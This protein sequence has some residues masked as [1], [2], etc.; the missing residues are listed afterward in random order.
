[1][2]SKVSVKA[3]RGLFVAV[4]LVL[5][6]GLYVLPQFVEYSVAFQDQNQVAVERSLS[7]F[8]YQAVGH[9]RRGAWDRFA[10]YAAEVPFGA[11]FARVGAAAGAFSK[12]HH[13][14]V[15]FGYK[16]F[17]SDNFWITALVEIGL[18]G[19]V[20]ITLLLVAIL[21]FGVRNFFKI[22]RP[23]LKI[24]HLAVLCSLI[25]IFMGLYGAEGVL[26]NPES[27]FFWFFSGVLMKLPLLDDK[28]A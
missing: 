24:L 17:F 3:T 10:K 8:D 27:S 4:G 13:Q 18:P 20:F 19:M 14:D 9:A 12:L 22:R 28:Q 1:M 26:Y 11:G 21:F 25:S 16:H 15:H 7:L 6:M 23:S 5:V 2:A